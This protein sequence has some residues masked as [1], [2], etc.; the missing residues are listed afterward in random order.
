MLFM[1]AQYGPETIAGQ[2]EKVAS[3]HHLSQGIFFKNTY[4]FWLMVSKTVLGWNSL[5]HHCRNSKGVV[6]FRMAMRQ[7]CNTT[8]G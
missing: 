5:S 1:W 6:A 8:Q 3:R 7:M 4:I 2:Q